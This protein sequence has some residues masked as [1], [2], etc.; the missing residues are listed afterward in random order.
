MRTCI[1]LVLQ[2]RPL[3][4]MAAGMALLPGWA[5]AQIIPR[6]RITNALPR[7]E[8]MVDRIIAA[9]EVPGLSIAII[10][11]DEVVYRKGFGLR[12]IG[13]PDM[14]GADTVFQIAS[15]SKPVSSIVVAALVGEGGVSWD[16]R[17]ADIDPAFRLAEA[18]PT[19]MVTIRDLFAHR[20]GLPGGAGDDLEEIG[21]GRDE[22]LQRLRVL[23]PASSFRSAYAYSNFG[24]TAGAVAAV[25]STG[26]S[27]EDVAEEK[28]YRPL[29]MTL[30]S[31]RHADFLARPDR[32]ALHIRENGGWA[33]KVQRNPDPQSPAGGVSSTVGDLANWARLELGRGMFG[34]KR[35]IAADALDQTHEPL[36]SRGLNPVT[37]AQSFYGLGWNVEFGQYGLTWGH[38]GAFSA[39]ARSL[40]T[41]YP[42]SSL[43]IVVLSNAFPTGVP[44]GVSDSFAD[45]VFDG[46][47]KTDWVTAWNKAYAGLFG[48][49]IEA[50]K[51]TY[52]TPPTPPS[53]SL[54]PEAYEG[55]YANS[56]VGEAIV[57]REGGGLVLKVGPGEGQ[58]TALHHFDRD[59][60]LTYPDADI[61]EMPSA[62][63]FSIG[64]YGRATAV[65][66]DSLDGNGLGTLQRTP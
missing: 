48:P 30:T 29:G 50:A 20:S 26:R 18:Y 63:R 13:K 17:V 8:A 1:G 3:F 39:G 42:R 64:P 36:M 4:A 9:K 41:L 59:L 62:V 44:E 25:R 12:E 15:L 46:D 61:P 23:P 32:A 10:H 14:V 2:R 5:Q 35:L 22:I 19:S 60:Y 28:L 49:A 27:W 40:V 11:D 45:M 66:I 58:T 57:K 51:T 16:S 55:H 43:G 6:E 21:Y 31:S 37:Q 38:A 52:A 34:G 65:T 56:Y 47:V 24:L 33:A 54:A 7:L 53:P